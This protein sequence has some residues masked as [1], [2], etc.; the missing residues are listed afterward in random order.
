MHVSDPAKGWM[1]WKIW[2]VV[3]SFTFRQR[4][5]VSFFLMDISLNA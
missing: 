5:V 2:K 1:N 3:M 4:V